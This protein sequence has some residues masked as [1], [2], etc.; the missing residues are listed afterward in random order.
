MANSVHQLMIIGNLGR[1]PEMRFTPSNQAVTTMSVATT[2]VYNNG[3]GEK[4]EETTWF[5][6][7]TWGKQAETVNQYLKKGAK[8]CVF[9]RLNPDKAGNPRIW[10]KTDGSKGTSYEVTANE[11]H[12][13][14][15][16][17]AGTAVPA[18]GEE[19]SDTIPF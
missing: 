15:G 19:V 11:V 6:V 2:R 4:Q 14:S 12:F 9:G 7:T 13:L 1:D 10:E 16:T 5:R 3:A 17:G 8:V 18:D